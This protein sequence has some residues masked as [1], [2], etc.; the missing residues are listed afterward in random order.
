MEPTADDILYRM[1]IHENDALR[2]RLELLQ[3]QLAEARKLLKEANGR[4]LYSGELGER[5]ADLLKETK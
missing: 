4:F 5:I 3:A 2:E 1:A